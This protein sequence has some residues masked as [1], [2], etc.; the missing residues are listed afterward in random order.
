MKMFTNLYEKIM[1]WSKHAHA[2]YY[3]FALSFAESSFFPI[4][5]DF[6]LAPMVLANREKGWWYAF[7]TTLAS[8]LGALLGYI[9]GVFFLALIYPIIVHFGYAAA[10][11]KVGIWFEH[12]N[13]WVM[14]FAGFAIIPYKIFTIAAGAMHV[15]LIPFIIGSIIGRG[16]RFFLVTALIIW[17]GER[18]ESM[19]ARYIE[20]IGWATVIGVALGVG[21][22]QL[23]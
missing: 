3:L 20:H 7:I 13:F 11:H 5:P 14:I 1:R 8:V 4:P 15:S 17:K 18:V 23:H 10:Y 19:L 9:L 21:I 12:W 2:P 6:M 16:G 22:Y